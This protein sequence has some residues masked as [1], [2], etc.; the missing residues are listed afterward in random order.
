[1]RENVGRQACTRF[2]EKILQDLCKENMYTKHVQGSYAGVFNFIIILC[3]NEPNF[4]ALFMMF[5]LI[6]ELFLCSVHNRMT[7]TL[8]LK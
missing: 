5:F 7:I 6:L 3:S 4:Y 2:K 8:Y 1:M